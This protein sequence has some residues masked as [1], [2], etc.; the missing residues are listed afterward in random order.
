MVVNI[1]WVITLEHG[2]L[3]TFLVIM[4]NYLIRRNIRVGGFLTVG[5]SR[6]WENS[7]GVYSHLWVPANRNRTGNGARL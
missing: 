4:S 1:L 5:K 2:I 6:W 7:Y 3:L